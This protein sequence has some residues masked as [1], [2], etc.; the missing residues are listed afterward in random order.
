MTGFTT[1]RR[2]ALAL[3][4]AA[5]LFLAGCTAARVPSGLP[6]SS[7]SAAPQEPAADLTPAEGETLGSGNVRVALLLPLSGEGNG[8]R[9]ASEFRN[10]AQ[11]A[12]GDSNAGPIQLV[13]K[14]TQGTAEGARMAAQ[15]AL[16]ERASAVL[17]PVFA[18]NVRAA[19]AVLRP[20]NVPM[21][22]FSSDR[23]V[24][25]PGVYLNSFLPGG[26]VDR[27]LSYAVSQDLRTVVAIVPEGQAGNVALAQARDTLTRTGA[28]LAAAARYQYDFSSVQQAVQSTAQALGTSDALFIPDGGKTPSAVAA[29]VTG[30]GVDLSSKQLLGTGQWSSANL[31]DPMLAGALFADTDHERIARYKQQYQQRYGAQPSVNSALAFDTVMLA[32]NIVRRHGGQGFGPEVIEDPSGFSGYTGIFRFRPDGTSERGYAVYEVVDGKAQI[33]SPAPRRFSGAS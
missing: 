25:G 26:I 3:F 5:A 32:A 16:D 8:A 18:E 29:A 19:A 15:Q 6:S 23:S 28:T 4:G 1:G 13:I 30:A 33:A 10:A 24:A 7:P 11:L 31:G 27:T 22:A 14:D 2:G 9:I 12:M 21:I 20:A 17:G